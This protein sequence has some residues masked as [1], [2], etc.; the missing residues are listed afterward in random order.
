M[1]FENELETSLRSRFTLICVI[2]L[3]EDRALRAIENVCARGSRPLS[4]WD[5]ADGFI[6]SLR[7]TA[8][9]GGREAEPLKAKDPLSL[10][11]EIGKLQT[12]GVFVLRDFHQCWDK[13]PRVI[14]KLRNLARQF[15]Y[16]RK[17]IIIL[18]PA[19][20][21]PAE[22]R[23][24]AVLMEFA[25]P[26]VPELSAI[27]DQLLA[28]PGVRSTLAP[29]ARTRLLR[30]ALGLSSNQAQRVFAKAI[31]TG[32]LLEEVDIGLVLAE[33]KQI[34]RESGALE[35]YDAHETS[36]DVGGLGVL[37]EWLRLRE[38]AL[39]P[40]ARAYGLPEP[41][42]L[43][44]IGIPGTGKSLTAKMI[45]GLWSL[46]LVRLDVGALFGGLVGQSEANTRRALQLVET[47]APC[48]LWI[49]EMEKALANGDGDAGTSTRVFGSLL[50]WMQDKKKPVFVVATA[51]NISRLPPELL[52][53]GR[54]DEIFFL[55]LPTLAERR[56]I[57]AVHLRKRK[58]NPEAFDLTALAA[59]SEG[60]VGSEIEQA[61]IDAMYVAFNDLRQP[62]REFTTADVLTALRQ[63]VPMSQSHRESIGA[64]RQWLK[65][66]RAQSASFA[67]ANQARQEC[68]QLEVMPPDA[69]GA[70]KRQHP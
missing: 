12:D 13:Q 50:S 57:V 19:A 9:E 36:A 6:P 16:S 23:D 30:S 54:F 31:V 40:E 26:G 42:G 70:A 63:Q 3:E 68:V 51:N 43:A 41:K 8:R 21:V 24:D 59:A 53:R 28:T 44:L 5:H 22:L 4:S 58:R 62:A 52:R 69:G 37:K 20:E 39:G 34:I 7:D 15:K 27:L 66:G 56:E 17:S 18:M 60:Y 47:I 48:V 10:L 29:D 67:D 33:K 35:F 11:D 46:P 64:L 1:D 49:D 45:S 2:S 55:D 14:R 32:G 65:E 61:V 25:P 38:R